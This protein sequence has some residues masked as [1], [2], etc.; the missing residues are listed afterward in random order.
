[1]WESTTCTCKLRKA[2]EMSIL[3]FILYMYILAL[4][5]YLLVNLLLT[6]C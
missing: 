3:K 6:I 4:N 1:M 2:Y 5:W